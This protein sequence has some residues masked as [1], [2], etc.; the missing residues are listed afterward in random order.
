MNAVF[1]ALT[2]SKIDVVSTSEYIGQ[3]GYGLYVF[4]SYTPE[5]LPDAAVWLI[6]SS[7]SIADSGFGSRGIVELEGPKKIIMSNSTST[8]ARKLLDGVSGRDIYISE[9]VKYT[10]YIAATVATAHT[11]GK[12]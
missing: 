7:S 2:D 6:N 11:M 9:Y 5:S 4:H 1:D 10:S 12:V 8:K 3:T